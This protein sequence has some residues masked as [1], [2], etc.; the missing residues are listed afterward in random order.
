MRL[1]LLE[2]RWETLWRIVPVKEISIGVLF[3]A[4]ALVPLAPQLAREIWPTWLLFASL[5]ALN[6]ICIAVWERFLD[7]AQQ[8]TSIA[9]AF[10]GVGWLV[11]PALVSVFAASVWL[12]VSVS[13]AADVRFCIAASAALLALVHLV[14]RRIPQDVRTALA[15]L[16]LLT[17]LVALLVG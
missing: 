16:V 15:D 10:P 17:P 13:R 1:S 6:C 14:R 3:A 12:A 5:C 7:L 11:I 4:G 8:R 9:T 2:P